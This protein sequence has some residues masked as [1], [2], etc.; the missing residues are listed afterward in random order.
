[1]GSSGST[2]SLSNSGRGETCGGPIVNV[3]IL[4]RISK[5]D[6]GVRSRHRMGAMALS[7]GCATLDASQVFGRPLISCI[8][9]GGFHLAAVRV[10]VAPI[11]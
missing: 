2:T 7:S 11:E 8:R 1:M 3:P 4:P 6:E 9:G 10:A 5:H